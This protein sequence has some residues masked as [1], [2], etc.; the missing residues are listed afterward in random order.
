MEP[1]ENL[2]EF[3]ADEKNRK[4]YLNPKKH[5]LFEM[6][7][8]AFQPICKN[9]KMIF[10]YIGYA[11]ATGFMPL[12][13]AIIIFYLIEILTK[14]ENIRQ[15]VFVL[16]IYTALY[17]FFGVIEHQ[18][19]HRTYVQFT[20]YRIQLLDEVARKRAS[21][22][23]GLGENSDFLNH[24]EKAF[25]A[26]SSNNSGIEGV[27]HVSFKLGGQL[28]CI[29]LSGVLLMRLSPLIFMFAVLGIFI[30]LLI[31]KYTAAYK[32]ERVTELNKYYRRTGV[33]GQEATDFSYGK[34]LRLYHLKEKVLSVFDSL[35]K[36]Y[37]FFFRK[38]LRPELIAAPFI[39]LILIAIEGL[40]YFFLGKQILS[41]N[42]NLPTIS[43]LIL[44]I[45]LFMSTS[46]EIL[47][48]LS[49]IRENMMYFSDGM[50]VVSADLN[51]KTGHLQFDPSQAI[52]VTFQNVT[53]HYPGS[54]K[55]V[56]DN[57][58][59]Q[60][61]AGERL[62]LV[63]VNGAGKT[64]L[65]KLLT[66]LYQPNAGEILFNGVSANEYS[67]SERFKM[68]APVLQEVDPLAFTIAQNVATSVDQID[69]EKVLLA[70]DRVGLTEKIK[71]LPKGID[72]SMT[73]VIDDDGTLFSGGENQK[74]AIARALYRED[75]QIM[76]LD[77]PT[78][79]LDALAEEKIYQEIDQIVGEK[80]LL[81]IS[82]RLA[83]TKF[84]DR[85]ILLD[86]G[87]IAEQGTHEKLILQ[88]NLYAE[89]FK[90]QGKYYQNQVNAA[91]S[92][93]IP[94]KEDMNN[95]A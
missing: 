20:R 44:L 5:S 51:S 82:H 33:L 8:Y 34:D 49:S 52:E 6:I 7:T 10:A 38:Y 1:K 68:F 43:M 28:L 29:I 35:I 67:I 65:V 78:A 73:K 81:F 32:Y 15:Y 58:S 24:F 55:N 14:Q 87:T 71:L 46:V 94:M 62:A 17:I 40:A 19:Y 70:L 47:D 91:D 4:A 80:S 42:L 16:I 89:M 84:C 31:R 9:T 25:S 64:T 18:L 61:H 30:L 88:N 56:L 72:T 77:E 59:F 85:I 93:M 63:G 57:I 27:Y 86:G 2:V 83:S 22:D 76:I 90:T 41:T 37:I 92:G 45:S 95:E 79:S 23:L 26:F 74:L 75:A 36:E 11:F 39:A 3:L 53:F 69:R 66:G 13:N 60:I 48:A 12:F 21:M 50:D 54:D